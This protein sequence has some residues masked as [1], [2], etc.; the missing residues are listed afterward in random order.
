LR[1][2]DG[3]IIDCTADHE[4]LRH[5]GGYTAAADLRKGDGLVP[6]YRKVWQ[7]RESVWLPQAGM[8]LPTHWLADMWN[9][10]HGVYAELANAHRHHNDLYYREGFDSEAY[11]GA[12]PKNHKIVGIRRLPGRHSVWCLTS[13]DSGNFALTS[14]VVAKNCGLI[15]NV[16]PIEAGWRGKITVEISNSSP[17]PA[18]VYAGEGIMQ[19]VFFRGMSPCEKSYADKRSGQ[20]GKYQSQIGLTL[21]KVD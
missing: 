5:G 21:P 17:I 7:G 13:V 20:P 2:D 9:V 15:V 1:L 16:T 6:L 14:G 3:S 8:W 4:F 18:K 12:A 10:R 11:A 19:L